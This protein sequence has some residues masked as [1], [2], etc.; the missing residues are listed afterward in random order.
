MLHGGTN[1]RSRG[2]R[3]GVSSTKQKEKRTGMPTRIDRPCITM[4]TWNAKRRN[5][6]TFC[7]AIV[8]TCEGA[9][10]H[11]AVSK[12]V[13]ESNQALRKEDNSY[14]IGSKEKLELLLATHFPGSTLQTN[15]NTPL[16]ATK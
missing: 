13:P 8:N 11:S 4:R 14:T 7:E 3:P 1:W 6:R 15:G 5:Y 10:L 9:R 12:A 16:T 2:K